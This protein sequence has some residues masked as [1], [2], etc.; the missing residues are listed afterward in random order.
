MVPM[1]GEAVSPQ[2]FNKAE[3][4]D[5][6]IQST[7]FGEGSGTHDARRMHQAGTYGICSHGTFAIPLEMNGQSSHNSYTEM[8]TDMNPKGPAKINPS[9]GIHCSDNTCTVMTLAQFAHISVTHY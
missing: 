9:L 5:E 8:C 7:N 6:T 3:F 2:F 4:V 1:Y